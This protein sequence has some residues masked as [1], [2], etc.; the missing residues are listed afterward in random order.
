VGGGDGPDFAHNTIGMLRDRQL[1]QE[2]SSLH[3]QLGAGEGIGLGDAL[4]RDMTLTQCVSCLY[5]LS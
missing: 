4:A 2:D 3:R 5:D 1:R